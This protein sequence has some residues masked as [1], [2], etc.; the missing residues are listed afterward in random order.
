M[1]EEFGVLKGMIPA[2]TGVDMH[3]LAILQVSTPSN[4]Q[5]KGQQQNEPYFYFYFIFT[6]L[7]DA[8]GHVLRQASSILNISSNVW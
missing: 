1:N 6:N 7:K 2:C 3:K 5:F 4:P 8:N